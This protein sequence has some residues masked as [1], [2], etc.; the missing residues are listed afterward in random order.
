MTVPRLIRALFWTFTRAPF[1]AIATLLILGFAVGINVGIFSFVK[2]C[3]FNPLPFLHPDSLVYIQKVSPSRSEPLF[4]YV[5]FSD[6]KRSQTCFDALS[7]SCWDCFDLTRTKQPT[8]RLQGHYCSSDI[9]K[10]SAAPFILGHPFTQ[11]DDTT[12]GPLQVVLNERTWK[13]IFNADQEILGKR[14][15]L[16]GYAFQVI[17]VCP[18][19]VCDLGDPPS[20]IYL[21][22]HCSGLYGYTF[23][24]RNQRVWQVFGRLRPNFNPLAGT[25]QLTLIYHNLADH[26]L[27]EKKHLRIRAVPLSS[28][29]LNQ[30][31]T[32]TWLIVS[33]SLCL[34]FISIANL[35]SLINV[36]ANSLRKDMAIRLALG[37]TRLQMMHPFINEIFTLSFIG[38]LFGIVIAF[39]TIHIIKTWAPTDLYRIQQIQLD[40][41]SLLGAMGLFIFAILVAGIWP[42]WR[43]ST[44][45]PSSVI[46]EEG[47]ST[48]ASPQRHRVPSCLVLCQF[49]LVTILLISTGLLVR[50]LQQIQDRPL[51]FNPAHVMTA[52]VYPTNVT[53]Y[54]HS[55]PNH[56]HRFFD[57]LLD[58]LRQQPGIASV[59]S[60]EEL[61]FKGFS[62]EPFHV[63]GTPILTQGNEPV[64]YAQSISKDYFY[65]LQIPLLKGRDFFQSDQSDTQKV[66]IVDR[67]FADHFFPN[68]TA[69]GQQIEEGSLFSGT[70]TWTIIGIVAKSAGDAIGTPAYGAFQV[71]F[72]YTQRNIGQQYV[73]LRTYG[74]PIDIIPLLNRSVE[75]I[76]PDVPLAEVATFD[77]LISN[78]YRFRKLSIYLVSIFG[79]ASLALSVSGIYTLQTLYVEQQQKNIA[80]RIALGASTGSILGLVFFR[81]GRLALIGITFGTAIVIIVF[82]ILHSILIDTAPINLAVILISLVAMALPIGVACVI[83]ALRAIR[84]D[85]IRALKDI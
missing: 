23:Q 83:P 24:D 46:R 22:L 21:P 51:G 52:Y 72:P 18:D 53:K 16:S 37:A 35:S 59:A 74:N 27:S 68:N 1:F 47:S 32:I 66:C 79:V 78:H 62:L 71:Y 45:C 84:I 38:G 57:R 80:I 43:L 58:L 9:F 30:Y 4:S 63:L 56:I 49:S 70:N 28:V 76:D 73:V 75:S 61:P 29:V 7:A 15:Q 50:R 42:T 39:G 11:A 55:N 13:T 60:N 5:V 8:I 34:F 44:L 26:Y 81:G 40:L 48:T 6:L 85:P 17:G 82:S 69:I 77:Q 3:F 20:D 12:G 2:T 10:V 14:I 67:A 33:A 65:T 31:A 64:M 25:S 41:V 54:N 19:Q 36:R